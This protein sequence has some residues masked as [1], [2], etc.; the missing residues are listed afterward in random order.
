MKRS[1]F[2]LSLALCGM[3]SAHAQVFNTGQTLSRG[4]FSVG[5]NPVIL[6][7][8]GTDIGIYLQGGLGLTRGIDLS[9]NGLVAENRSF[10]GGDIEW[11]LVSGMPSLS[12]TTGAA[13]ESGHLTL[14]TNANL[15]FPLP[16]VDLYMG[17]KLDI[18][19]YDN[20]VALP[21]WLFF[22]AEVRV[23]STMAIPFEVDIGLTSDATP[24]IGSGIIIY[25]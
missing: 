16:S 6:V 10:V 11:G 9:I 3:T 20:D 19:I 4:S 21:F 24:L 7:D 22:G 14:K 2:V 23:K 8:G 5:F 17:P 12:L 13:A 15:T 18:R 1:I 25:F